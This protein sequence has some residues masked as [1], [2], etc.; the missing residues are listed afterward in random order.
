MRRKLYSLFLTSLAHFSKIATSFLILKFISVYLGV[1]GVG[2]LGNYMSLIAAMLLLSGGGIS[3]GVIKY[4]SLYKDDSRK[5]NDFIFNAS[6]YMMT[7]SIILFLLFVF[8]AKN[9]SNVIFGGE[10]IDVIYFLGFAQFLIAFVNFYFSWINGIGKTK[11][12]LYLQ[13]FSFV[14][15]APVSWFLIK[16]FQLRGAAYA[17]VIVYVIPLI[18]IMYS[19]ERIQKISF[20]NIN[21]YW[22][23]KIYPFSLMA[24]TSFFSAP[25]VEI[26]IRNHLL[27]MVDYGEV[28]IWQAAMRLSSAY[29][30]FFFIFLSYVFIPKISSLIEKEKIAKEVFGMIGF[31]WAIFLIGGLILL[32]NI[33][34]FTALFLSPDFFKIEKYIKYQLVGDFFRVGSFVIGY[35]FIAKSRVKLYIFIEVFQ[36]IIFFLLSLNS[37][38]IFDEPLKGVMGSYS[39]S[40]FISFLIC[41]ILFFNVLKD[42]FENE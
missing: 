12:Y 30:G 7:A 38:R 18:G 25:V 32:I 2:A 17:L 10:Y 13:I 23:R 11:K 6:L 4:C 20:K 41:I 34:F 22:W 1:S 27:K 33:D 39:M 24:I 19:F 31:V 40:F 21:F 42:G 16:N 37:M 9:I 3:N 36:Y 35:F 14:F 8:L 26:L 28:G 5:L 29:L 15:G